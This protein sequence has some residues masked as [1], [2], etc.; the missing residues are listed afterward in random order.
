MKVVVTGGSGKA[1]RATVRE[2]LEHGHDVLN[3]DVAPPR[4]QISR[5]LTVDLMELGEV[6]GVGASKLDR[7]GETFLRVLTEQE[8][9]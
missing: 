2:L 1:G 4:E 5:F 8:M 6:S 3:V 7:Y 9:A